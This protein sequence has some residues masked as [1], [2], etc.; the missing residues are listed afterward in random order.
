M[1]KEYSNL[2]YKRVFFYRPLIIMVIVSIS[3]FLFFLI[4]NSI[5]TVLAITQIALLWGVIGYLIPLL[6]LFFNY[7]KENSKTIL[8][9]LNGDKLTYR[10]KNRFIEFTLSDIDKV[11]LN[12]SFPLYHKDIRLFFWDE[13]YYADIK[14]KNGENIIITCL[15]CDEI[16]QIIPRNL[17]E[18][19]RR[20][21]QLI[22]SPDP[23]SIK[24]SNKEYNDRVKSLMIK[25]EK[26]SKS[27]LKNIVDNKDKFQKEA[28]E[29]AKNLLKFSSLVDKL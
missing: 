26:K 24:Y 17:I 19:K 13:Y 20:I 25:F 12:L 8:V 10:K 29:A 21:F 5:N 15:L 18:R 27:E 2:P 23:E 1:R 7:Q 3:V 28:V 4:N 16:E 6:I 9:I 14:L 11:V 22:S